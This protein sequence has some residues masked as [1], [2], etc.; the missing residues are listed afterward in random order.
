MREHFSLIELDY[1][2]II[3]KFLLTLSCFCDFLLIY[4]QNRD[5]ITDSHCNNINHLNNKLSIM[6]KFNV[7]YD[8]VS[9][10][11]DSI[12]SETGKET[13]SKDEIIDVVL[14]YLTRS[15]LSSLSEIAS[16]QELDRWSHI[17]LLSRLCRDHIIVKQQHRSLMTLSGHNYY[18]IHTT[19]SRY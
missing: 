16:R 10:H 17:Y 5:Y 3:F 18:L 2:K 19:Y 11:I 6:S 14:R 13:L 4:F 15:R 8:I 1:V 9:G 12:I 7:P